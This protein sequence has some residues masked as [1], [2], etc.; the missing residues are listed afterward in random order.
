MSINP[1]NMELRRVVPTGPRV[2]ATCPTCKILL[3]DDKCP[4]CDYVR[5]KGYNIEAD[6]DMT[7]H[8]FRKELNWRQ[9]FKDPKGK[10]HLI[11]YHFEVASFSCPNCKTSDWSW[12]APQRTGV[13]KT[14]LGCHKTTGPVSLEF[15]E[16][17]EDKVVEPEVVFDVYK[18]RGLKPPKDLQ[19][20]IMARRSRIRK[21][22]LRGRDKSVE[23]F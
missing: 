14:C 8:G 22:R 1:E 23:T 21:R 19:D 20:E 15:G 11:T 16:L 9:I 12:L 10:W 5:V 6:T 2:K 13:Y 17:V 3:I 7:G 4:K 18:A